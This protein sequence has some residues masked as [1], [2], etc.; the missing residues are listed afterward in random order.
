MPLPEL[1]SSS[2]SLDGTAAKFDVD[3]LA[4]QAALVGMSAL[5]GEHGP[6]RDS[7]IYSGAIMLTHMG[8]GKDLDDSAGM[9][10]T[11]IDS[12]K[13]LKHFLGNRRN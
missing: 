12:G 8:I 1:D 5:E 2:H 11:A 4:G 7:L 6:A 10:R 13:A 9:V 3:Q